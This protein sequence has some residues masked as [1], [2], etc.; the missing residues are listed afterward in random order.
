MLLKA[1]MLRYFSHISMLL[2]NQSCRRRRLD[3]FG[4]EQPTDNRFQGCLEA[5]LE[6]H[7]EEFLLLHPWMVW[8]FRKNVLNIFFLT[9]TTKSF[10]KTVS[11][12]PLLTFCTKLTKL[13]VLAFF[14]QEVLFIWLS[15]KWKIATTYHQ[16]STQD[17]LF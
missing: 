6:I 15:L 13:L 17:L 7:A 2:S 1:K 14:T 11:E 9:P 5:C 10:E 3:S 4:I 16:K 8:F 12:S